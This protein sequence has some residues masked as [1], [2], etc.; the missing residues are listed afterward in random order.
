MIEVAEMKYADHWPVWAV[1][2]DG[3]VVQCCQTEKEAQRITDEL[4]REVKQ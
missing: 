2:N 3:L 4:N 1:L